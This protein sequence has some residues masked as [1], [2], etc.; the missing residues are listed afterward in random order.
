MSSKS[1]YRIYLQLII[2]LIFAAI[3]SV[4]AQFAPQAGFAGT[5]AIHKDSSI[6]IAWGKQATANLGWQN[7][8]DTSLGKVNVG[9]PEF[10]IGKPDG[11]I[12]SLGDGGSC[13]ITFDA[14]IFNGP[15]FD[16]AIFEN[17]FRF[18]DTMYFLEL[19]T[20]SVSSDGFNFVSFEPT[21]LSPTNFQT[22][23]FSGTDARL[24]NNL[25]GK[26]IT[27]F[28]TPFDLN[29]LKDNNLL[30]VNAITHIKITDVVG[31]I[32]PEFA[33]KDKYNNSINDPWPT[34]FPSGGF[35]LDAVGIIHQ[36]VSLNELNKLSFKCYPNP[37]KTNQE[38][39]L[40]TAYPARF[41]MVDLTGKII[42]EGT[43]AVGSIQAPEKSGIYF[44]EVQSNGAT[45]RIKLVVE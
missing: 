39:V 35:D 41:L 7:I 31:S 36:A 20:V 2:W 45:G 9:L 38:L 18:N 21:S 27:P 22:D 14:P 3:Q 43:T 17:G 4:N 37:A 1:T 28:G 32:L 6:F 16:F 5:T 44:I 8:A 30:N 34:A 33:T 10:V 40:N 11:A 26:Y 13:T 25:A 19:A 15:G 23:A 12:I 24:I 29:E 42:Q